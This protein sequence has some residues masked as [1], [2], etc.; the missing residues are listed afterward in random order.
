[1]AK[2]FEKKIE[3][4]ASPSSGPNSYHRFGAACKSCSTGHPGKVNELSSPEV[5]QG[6]SFHNKTVATAIHRSQN[7]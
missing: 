3:I 7:A 1:M 4:C 2:L 6:C 5:A